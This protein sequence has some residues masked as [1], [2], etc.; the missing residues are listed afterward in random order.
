MILGVLIVWGYNFVCRW[1]LDMEE[2]IILYS[3]QYP[4][5]GLL[6]P[7]FGIKAGLDI[8]AR[9]TSCVWFLV[10]R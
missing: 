1:P 3:V 4:A 9:K 6:S 10:G 8:S 7:R 5:E 2:L